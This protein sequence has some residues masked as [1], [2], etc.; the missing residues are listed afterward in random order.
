M[1]D[2]RAGMADILKYV[3]LKTATAEDEVTIGGITY[4]SDEQLQEYVDRH[5]IDMRN[6][7]LIPYPE[8]VDGIR[9]TV[10][11][12]L[13]QTM[14]QWVE[15]DTLTVVDSL[16]NAAPTYT[17]DLPSRL[18]LFDADTLGKAYYIRTR[19][20]DVRPAIADI[21]LDKV[22]LRVELIDWKAGG[23]NLA[24]DQEYQHCLDQY[25]LWSEIGGIQTTKM[26]KVGYQHVW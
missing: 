10:R 16:G 7:A 2:V 15:T 6:V 14:G 20:Y 25:K 13:P 26:K 12:Y 9:S 3:R 11:Y 4:W 8:Y 5:R 22:G 17:V 23:Q 24:E 18:V 1:T 19:F 21:W